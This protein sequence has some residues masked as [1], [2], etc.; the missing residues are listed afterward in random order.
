MSGNI[1]ETEEEQAIIIDVIKILLPIMLFC[2]EKMSTENQHFIWQVVH[3]I[4][5]RMY[6]CFFKNI[7]WLNRINRLPI[8]DK[9]S[10]TIR[11]T[12]RK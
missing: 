4:A 11:R 6:V 12:W 10:G 8:G 1:L 7:L 9:L 2:I 3:A 5:C